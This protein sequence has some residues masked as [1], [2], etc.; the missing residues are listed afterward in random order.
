MFNKGVRPIIFVCIGII[1]EELVSEEFAAASTE[2][3]AKLF[4]GK[5]KFS[6]KN[7]H[8]PFFKKRI[9][10]LEQTIS[11]KFS[12]E[13]KKAIYDGWIVTA[14]LLSDPK[15]YAYLVFIKRV[16]DK[17]MPMPKGT[18]TVPVSE[19]RII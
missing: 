15:D 11:L 10:F 4:L 7:I 8:G 1:N 17:K 3:A 12:N 19:L 13:T 5:H 6:A 14:F 2:E 9:K 18:V 16:D